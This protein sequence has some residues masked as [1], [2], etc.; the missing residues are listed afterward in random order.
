MR[1]GR[2]QGSMLKEPMQDNPGQRPG[3]RRVLIKEVNWLG[4]LVMSLPA[5]RLLR[6]AFATAALSV[7]I[8]HELSGFFDGIDWVDEVI[9]YTM[10]AGVR[11]WAD[12]RKIIK[13]LRTRR[14]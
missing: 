10:R 12:Q 13:A 3:T 4:D 14:F 2:L 1:G 11:G 8:R 6:S 7:L 5:L 9:P